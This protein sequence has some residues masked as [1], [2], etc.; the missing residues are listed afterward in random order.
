MLIA[1]VIPCG[2]ADHSRLLA[3]P[4]PPPPFTVKWL[5][6]SPPITKSKGKQDPGARKDG[7]PTL[8]GE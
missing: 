8:L 7:D 5:P 4:P 6:A 1:L 2:N 3:P